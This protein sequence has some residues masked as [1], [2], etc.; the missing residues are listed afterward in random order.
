MPETRQWFESE[1]FWLNYGPIM[2]DE[3]RWAEAKGVAEAV[4]SIAS[5]KKG[6]SV[7]DAGCG[8]GRISVEL[9]LLGMDVTG[10]D[11]IQ[12]YLDAARETAFETVS[13]D[14]S[15]VHVEEPLFCT[16]TFPLTEITFASRALT[17]PTARA[18]N[19]KAATALFIPFISKPPVK[20]PL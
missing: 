19:I 1:D 15:G 3:E 5:L 17:E 8:P 4:Y 9:S 18:A 16:S 20:I 13:P 6:A 10:V 14:L 7:L 11:M 12:P 2:F